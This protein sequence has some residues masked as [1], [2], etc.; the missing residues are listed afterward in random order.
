MSFRDILEPFNIHHIDEAEDRDR[1]LATIAKVMAGT[2]IPTRVPLHEIYFRQHG[3]RLIDPKQSP[4]PRDPREI[5]PT[6]LLHTASIL[7]QRSRNQVA[8]LLLSHLQY[9]VCRKL[10]RIVFLAPKNRYF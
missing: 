5:S 9:D 6:D 2:P 10:I 1:V 3:H 4:L 7:I 8:R